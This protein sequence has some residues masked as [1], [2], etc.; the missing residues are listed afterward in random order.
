MGKII[1]HD[2]IAAI[3][4]EIGNRWMTARDIARMVNKRGRY[5]K[6]AKAKTPDVEEF[7]IRL[8]AR[9][10]SHLFETDGDRIRLTK[11]AIYEVPNGDA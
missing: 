3:L 7:Q 6:T 4:A 8:R 11:G 9:N 10:Y 1:L 5:K 2:E